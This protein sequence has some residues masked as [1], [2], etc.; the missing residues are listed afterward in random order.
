[1]NGY[2]L[3]ALL[4]LVAIAT[5]MVTNRVLRAKY[6][7]ELEATK[8]EPSPEP[9]ATDK[10]T[11]TPE[12]DTDQAEKGENAFPDTWHLWWR[13]ISTRMAAH[14]AGVNFIMKATKPDDHVAHDAAMAIGQREGV[15]ARVRPEATPDVLTADE[16]EVEVRRLLCLRAEPTKPAVPA[17]AIDSVSV[18]GA[19]AGG[20]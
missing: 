3:F 17:D 16:L 19:A 20:A 10:A 4:G 1:M 8:P 2:L 7:A 6:A 12:P 15:L 13:Y 5:L 14:G 18:I 11:H 9:G